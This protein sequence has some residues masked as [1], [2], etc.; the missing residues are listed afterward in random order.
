[1][2]MEGFN[3][4]QPQ[5]EKDL[6]QAEKLSLSESVASAKI[7]EDVSESKESFLVV[8]ESLKKSGLDFTSSLDLINGRLAKIDKEV[9]IVSQ[10]TIGKF[11]TATRNLENCFQNKK[12]DFNEA[13]VSFNRLTASFDDLSLIQDRE[14]RK[15]TDDARKSL[16]VAIES[17]QDSAR[18]LRMN[19][20]IAELQKNINRMIDKAEMAAQK[21][22]RGSR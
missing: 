3:Q 13:V 6:M 22:R 9:E 16:L 10:G 19:E 20:S 11:R 15:I 21:L 2:G 17:S 18:A 4:I 14:L 7:S 1:M 8:D 5:E 12:F